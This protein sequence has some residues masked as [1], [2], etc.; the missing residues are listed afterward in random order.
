[1]DNIFKDIL[2]G[3]IVIIGIG[4]ILKADD[5][6]GPSLVNRLKAGLSAVCIDAGSAPEN[7]TGKILKENP[8]TVLIVDAV[9]LGR[10]PG[11]FALLEKKEILNCGFTTHDISCNMFIGYLEARTQ[12]KIYMLGIQPEKVNFSEGLSLS[13][14]KAI[15]KLEELIREAFYA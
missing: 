9:D 1:M 13:A 7:F 5:G 3:K 11:E 12:A 15:A 8:D 2:K 10:S 6:L 4:N 14:E